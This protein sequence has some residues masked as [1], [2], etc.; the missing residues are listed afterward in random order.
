MC[1]Q[2]RPLATPYAKAVMAM[3]PKT[4]YLEDQPDLE[5]QPRSHES[6]N[7]LP[8]HRSTGQ[9][10]FHPTS[11]SRVFTRQDAAKVF[12]EQLLPADERVPHPELAI[13]HK[14]KLQRVMPEERERR[15]ALR[16]QAEDEKTRLAAEAKAKKEAS[17]KRVDIGKWEYRFTNISVESA[18]KDGRG[19][20]GT[21]WRYGAP[22]MDRK[23]GAVRIPTAV[24]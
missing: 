2:K 17:I 19:R 1:L 8:V 14:E 7:D 15:A 5:K 10:I 24:E 3:L 13:L 11:E 4:L 12:H 23:K 22:H 20:N 6:I 9:Q 16:Q 21:G 18:G